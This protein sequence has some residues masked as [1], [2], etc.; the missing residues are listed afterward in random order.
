M[1]QTLSP[2]DIE[3]TN[4]RNTVLSVMV[5][6]R[7][8]FGTW[9]YGTNVEPEPTGGE[10]TVMVP[11]GVATDE[12]GNQNT[13]SRPLH[14]ARNRKVSVND[15]SAEEGTDGTIDFAVTLDTRNDCETVTVD[16]ATADGTATAGEDYTASSGTLTF[17]PGETTKT[18]SVAVLDDDDE[19]SDETFTLQL[20]NAKGAT[21]AD[22]QGMGTTLRRSSS[23]ASTSA[24]RAM[25]TI[26]SDDSAQINQQQAATDTDP[27]TV[28]VTRDARGPA[29][30]VRA[31]FD[32]TVTFSEAVS[33]FAMADL[34]VQRLCRKHGIQQR[35]ETV[36]GDNRPGFHLWLMS[37]RR[38][39]R[40]ETVRPL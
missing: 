31:R 12:V 29:G 15:A 23:P 13:A 36:H 2:G 17:N 16:W 25:G 21:F 33:G 1:E 32:V 24:A 34:E 26:E 27:P 11:A 35:W 18:V 40:T 5:G 37:T 10:A 7:S 20:S 8:P 4:A 19:E 9:S 22:S 30:L 14:I 28:T 3:L 38:R 39:C 6:Q